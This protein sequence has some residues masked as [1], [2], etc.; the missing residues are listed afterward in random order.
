MCDVC[1][2]AVYLQSFTLLLLL[3]LLCHFFQL[4]GR[5]EGVQQKT[6]VEDVCCYSSRKIT[7]QQRLCV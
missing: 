6:R 3:L 7:Q 5:R 2:A 4:L 1:L